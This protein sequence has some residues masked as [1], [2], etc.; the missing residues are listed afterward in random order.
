MS[1]IVSDKEKLAAPVAL[2]VCFTISPE[3]P[4]EPAIAPHAPSV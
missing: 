1:T 2:N 4:P 3:P